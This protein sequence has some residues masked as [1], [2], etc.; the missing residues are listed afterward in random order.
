MR[1]KPD[2]EIF[3][4]SAARLGVAPQCVLVFED[5]PKGIESAAAAGMDVVGVTTMLSA[6]EFSSFPNVRRVISTYEGLSIAELLPT[7]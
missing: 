3:L 1:G 7:R 2:P 4:T 5:A 6:E